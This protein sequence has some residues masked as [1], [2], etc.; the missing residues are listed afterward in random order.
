MKMF[1]RFKNI[2]NANVHAKLDKFEDPQKM[3]RYM[4]TEI[5][6]TLLNAKAATA[7][8]MASR[9]IIEQELSQAQ[10]SSQR[11]DKRATMAVENGSDEL[12]REALLEKHTI[13]KR[14][15]LL[16]DELT[17]MDQIIASMQEH[18]ATLATK[19]QE[20]RDKERLLIERAYHA[21]EKKKV[22]ETLKSLDCASACRKFAEFEEK[23]ERLEADAEMAG[24]SPTTK[25]TE[26][27]FAEL[28]TNATIEAEL[29]KLKAAQKKG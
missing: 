1:K 14:I 24:F 15:E 19:R 27:Q 21:K 10:K 20:I 9:T 26:Q 11:W 8:R 5:D 16:Q 4:L 25:S 17:Q 7:E 3:V 23:I 29:A 12:A 18:I 22:L 13:T 6:E 28:E 2:I